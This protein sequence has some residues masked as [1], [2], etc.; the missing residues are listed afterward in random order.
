MLLQISNSRL[1]SPRLP[2]NLNKWVKQ[3]GSC[4]CLGMSMGLNRIGRLALVGL[5]GSC[6]G[7][8]QLPP[9]PPSYSAASIGAD[10]AKQAGPLGPGM[11]VSIYGAHLGPD[12]PCIGKPDANKRETPSALRPSQTPAERMVFPEM[13]CD[14]EVRVGGVAAGLLYVSPGQI[15]FKIPQQIGVSGTA[16]IQVTHR[17]SRGPEV[18][19]PLG[20]STL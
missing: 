14:C 10:G 1:S 16:K 3:F 18:V 6:G 9:V 17:G 4:Y 7:G 13:L 5:L 12:A 11:I 19:V 2:P 20:G 15:N 8:N